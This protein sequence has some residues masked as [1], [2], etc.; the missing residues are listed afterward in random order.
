MLEVT[1]LREEIKLLLS[2]LNEIAQTVLED[3][4]SKDIELI[5]TVPH[6]HLSS[7]AATPRYI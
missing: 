5:Q 7:V 2:G 3:I 6:L 4:N 1:E